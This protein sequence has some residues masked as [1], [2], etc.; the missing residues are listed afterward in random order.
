MTQPKEVKRPAPHEK[1][2]RPRAAREGQAVPAAAPEN[3]APP[4]A[5]SSTFSDDF[6]KIIERIAFVGPSLVYIL[7]RWGLAGV[8]LFAAG[9]AFP[10]LVVALG[11][12][13]SALVSASY[14]QAAPDPATAAPVAERTRLRS[15][16]FEIVGKAD[17]WVQPY[18]DLFERQGFDKRKI[19]GEKGVGD[20][21]S[22]T[23][24]LMVSC[25]GTR[26]ST[27]AMPACRL[28]PPDMLLRIASGLESSFELGF[29]SA[30]AVPARSS[31][32]LMPRAFMRR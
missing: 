4:S 9:A 1:Q 16:S 17:E 8:C 5:A 19:S 11:L 27:H 23:T 2:P 26:T 28:P 15:I 14:K 3:A 31:R 6:L 12:Y 20:S 22:L 13:P 32:T 30:Q 18:A 24:G 29:G 25:G 7:K 21:T 10:M